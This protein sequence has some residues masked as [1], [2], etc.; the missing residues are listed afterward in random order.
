MTIEIACPSTQTR[1]ASIA[2]TRRQW[3]AMRRPHP[4][5]PLPSGTEGDLVEVW[6]GKPSHSTAHCRVAHCSLV[7][8]S[9]Q[10]TWGYHHTVICCPISR[11]TMNR[12]LI[13]LQRSRESGTGRVERSEWRNESE[14]ETLRRVTLGVDKPHS[15]AHVCH[16]GTG[17][18]QVHGHTHPR[19]QCSVP[20]AATARN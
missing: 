1:S 10:D 6:I 11:R 14:R 5:R 12:A 8:L 20:H 18:P 3:G 13:H 2:L 4:C 9:P 16:L 19:R 15:H 7:V 17:R